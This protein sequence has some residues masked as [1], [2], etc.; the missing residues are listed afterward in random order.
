MMKNLKNRVMA[1]KN[2]NILKKQKYAINEKKMFENR[3]GLFKKTNK[4]Y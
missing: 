2:T 3:T 4:H 1:E